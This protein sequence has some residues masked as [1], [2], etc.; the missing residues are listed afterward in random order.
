LYTVADEVKLDE[1]KEHD[2]EI[3]VDRIVVKD[4]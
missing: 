2:I 1:E 4:M 3:V